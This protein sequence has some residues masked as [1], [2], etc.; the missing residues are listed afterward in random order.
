MDCSMQSFFKFV[1][2]KVAWI[3]FSGDTVLIECFSALLSWWDLHALKFHDPSDL[4][5]RPKWYSGRES[6]APLKGRC[7]LVGIVKASLCHPSSHTHDKNHHKTTAAQKPIT[8]LQSVLWWDQDIQQNRDISFLNISTLASVEWPQNSSQSKINQYG[9][10]DDS[11]GK[12][13]DPCEIFLKISVV[14]DFSALG[15]GFSI[16][17][18][19]RSGDILF[20]HVNLFKVNQVGGHAM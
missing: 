19:S 9:K 15:I 6:K 18:L 12:K 1:N 17:L 20:D 2:W 5:P 10:E 4:F 8:L 7:Y 16:S 14:R 11:N 13:K 3:L